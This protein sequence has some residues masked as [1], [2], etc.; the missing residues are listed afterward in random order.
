ML[1]P[2]ALFCALMTTLSVGAALPMKLPRLKVADETYTNVTVVNVNATDLFFTYSKGIKNVKLRALEPEIQKLFDYDPRT[3]KEAERQRTENETKYE[4]AVASRQI[5]PAGSIPSPIASNTNQNAKASSEDNM[6]DS[7]SP[8]SP[9]GKNGPALEIE[10]WLS[11]APVLKGKSVLVYFWAPWSVPCRKAIPV[12]NSIQKKFSDN[13]Q[14]VA[15]MADSETDDES[16]DTKIEFASAVDIKGKLHDTL[17]VTMVPFVLLLD[18]RGIILYE[19]HPAAL[20][21]KQLQNIL[22][23]PKD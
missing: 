22:S 13:L 12:L 1:R 16:M 23:K 15:L 17:G 4:N 11:P 6:S 2:T 3:A 10:K 7:I 19:G 5:T 14:V 20:N 18:P 21:E 9:L 8:S